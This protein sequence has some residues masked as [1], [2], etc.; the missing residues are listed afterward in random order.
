MATAPAL[1][2]HKTFPS[3][4]LPIIKSAAIEPL[5]P[6]LF[7]TKICAFNSLPSGSAIVLATKSTG[8]PGGN[9]TNIRIT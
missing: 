2:N 1:V 9:A 7:S 3:A 8:P 5:P 6:G 4:G